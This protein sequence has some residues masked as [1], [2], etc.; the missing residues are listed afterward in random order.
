M[1]KVAVYGSLKRGFHNHPVMQQAQGE[2]KGDAVV[3]GFVMYDLGAFPGIKEGEGSIAVELYD[4]ADLEPLD[5]LEGYRED[6]E[7]NSFYLRR[8]AEIDG[9]DVLIYVYNGSVERF[10]EVED[11]VW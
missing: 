3:N 9:E 7:E 4:V 11:G 10:P 6:D 5:W 8:T 2:W 1:H